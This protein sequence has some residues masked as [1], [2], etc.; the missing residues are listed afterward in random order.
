MVF[1]N[2]LA[3]NST[4]NNKDNDNN[5]MAI[6]YL[7]PKY[8]GHWQTNV[9]FLANRK[10]CINDNDMVARGVLRGGGLR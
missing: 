7:L 5:I 1:P 2:D 3:N 9:F 8:Q 10:I 6:M 4:A